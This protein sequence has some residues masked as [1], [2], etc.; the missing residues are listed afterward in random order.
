M[1]IFSGLIILFTVVLV[2]ALLAFIF[3]PPKKPKTIKK[4]AVPKI[5]KRLKVE[6]LKFKTTP[7]GGIF[8]P[9]EIPRTIDSLKVMTQES[10]DLVVGVI[11]SWL[12]DKG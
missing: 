10:P 8:I 1:D 2:V 4:V 5:E 9:K 7:S 3:T 6:P 11:K 12:R